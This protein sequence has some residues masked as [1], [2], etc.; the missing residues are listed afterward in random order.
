[1]NS[2]LEEDLQSHLICYTIPM[3]TDVTIVNFLKLTLETGLLNPSVVEKMMRNYINTINKN[4]LEE[5]HIKHRNVMDLTKSLVLCQIK[6][7]KIDKLEE[8]VENISL[9]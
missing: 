9:K 5:H 3:E 6:K 4:T 8:Q 2:N 7:L 1:M